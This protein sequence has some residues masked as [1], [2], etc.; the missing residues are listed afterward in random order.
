MAVPATPVVPFFAT[1]GILLI[2]CFAK[3]LVGFADS[4]LGAFPFHCGFLEAAAS[5]LLALAMEGFL[6]LP[7]RVFKLD[8]KEWVRLVTDFYM[9]LLE[10]FYFLLMKSI[11][12]LDS[13]LPLLLQ[14]NPMEIKESRS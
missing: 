6:D 3:G 13:S 7:V 9:V 1:L 12:A 2:S 11:M 4:V 8:W 14:Q 10:S 5:A